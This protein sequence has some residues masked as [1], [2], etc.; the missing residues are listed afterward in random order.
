MLMLCCFA[1]DTSV[2]LR[3]HV[4]VLC[5]HCLFQKSEA[6]VAENP[7]PC[8]AAIGMRVCGRF[9]PLLT[10]TLRAVPPPC[11]LPFPRLQRHDDKSAG[12]EQYEH[13]HRRPSGWCPWIFQHLR[14]G[15]RG[16]W[17][18]VIFFILF[19]RSACLGLQC[20]A[21]ACLGS[22]GW[23]AGTSTEFAGTPAKCAGA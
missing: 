12:L 22:R 5:V 21:S 19:R 13:G 1:G 14:H 2:L 15:E 9:R 23:C 20:G 4:H 10:H 7:W 8:C 11:R 3:A 18:P 16:A 6:L 17:N